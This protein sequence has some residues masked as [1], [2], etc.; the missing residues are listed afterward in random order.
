LIAG[1]RLYCSSALRHLVPPPFRMADV[2]KS[3]NTMTGAITGFTLDMIEA[4]NV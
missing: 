2:A 1:V 3:N 4:E